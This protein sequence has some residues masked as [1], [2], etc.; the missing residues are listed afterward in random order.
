[1]EDCLEKVK[2]LRAKYP[3]VDIEVDG[4]V[5]PKNIDKCTHAGANVIVAGT[6]IFSAESPKETISSFRNSVY[7]NVT[8][9]VA[10]G[11]QL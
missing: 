9:K 3:H 11:F 1:M 10:S 8:A 7:K 5:G 2:T 6:S 4:G